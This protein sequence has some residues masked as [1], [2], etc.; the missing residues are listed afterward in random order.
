MS[1]LRFALRQLLK[2]PG[3]TAVAV[4]ALALGIGASTA[5]FSVLDVLL[6]RTPGHVR[7]AE[8]LVRVYPKG[9]WSSENRSFPDYADLRDGTAALA[10]VAAYQPGVD[11]TLGMGADAQK[12]S[13][14]RATASFFDLLGVAP[15][16]GRFFTASEDGEPDA[17]SVVVISHE[18]WQRHFA[19]SDDALGRRLA[20]GPESYEVIG[21]TPPGFT[22]VELA[23]ADFWL[24]LGT[25]TRHDNWRS[26]PKDRGSPWVKVIAR[27]KPGVSREAADREANAANQRGWTSSGLKSDGEVLRL[28]PLWR[29]RD[30]QRS[31]EVQVTLCLAVV[32]AGVLAIAAAN[33]SGLLLVRAWER[34][35][36][37]AIRQALGASRGRLLRQLLGESLLLGLLS[38]GAALVVGEWVAALLRAFVL[39]ASV[40]AA[41]SDPRVW[42]FNA[43]VALVVS[44]GCGLLSAATVLRSGGG[45]AALKPGG[46]EGRSPR[47]RLRAGLLVAQV[48]VTVVLLVVAGLFLRSLHRAV[49]TD[50]GLDADRLI[51]LTAEVE[52]DEARLDQVF[53]VLR[54][55][56]QGLPGVEQAS[57][58]VTAPFR[59]GW[60]QRLIPEGHEGV[61]EPVF[62]RDFFNEQINCVTP[63]Y[64]AA[65]GLHVRRG[66]GLTAA[67]RSGAPPVLVVNEAMARMLAPDTDVLGRR[68][69]IQNDR[70]PLAEVVGVVSDSKQ[71]EVLGPATPQYYVPFDQPLVNGKNPMRALLIRTVGEP[72]RQ[73][74]TIRRELT[75]SVPGLP[76]LNL[77]VMRQELEPQLLPWRLGATLLSLFSGL[78][79]VI[80]TVGLYGVFSHAVACRTREIGIRTALGADSPEIVRLVIRQGVRLALLGVGLGLAVAA[81]LSRLLT[82]LLYGVRP[83]DP[84]A[85]GAVLL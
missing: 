82:S 47:F 63:D 15:D 11:I 44:L 13:G 81:G 37:L 57:L 50:L 29:A 25:V 70:A 73:L 24:P 68:F 33:V 55:R 72:Q 35:S 67:D 1:D 75:A 49:T 12:L 27:L 53:R 22:G 84:V 46:S 26:W 28:G 38:G 20:L 66:R 4:L 48:T 42:G 40:T 34:R 14:A 78:A 7:D 71:S 60:L 62:A 9:W 69:R 54:E 32:A 6:L 31:R 21:I 56:L 8:S 30:R 43:G 83:L 65:T 19:G 79:L 45:A 61:A 74:E 52:G 85:F 41:T 36:E 10:A 76:Y 18:F 80:A 77:Q 39:P 16:R 17:Q 5:M 64:F 2:N 3:F 59:N 58:S 23:R 51:T